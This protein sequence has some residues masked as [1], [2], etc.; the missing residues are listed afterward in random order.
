MK[1]P[2]NGKIIVLDNEPNEAA[3]LLQVLAKN[4][5]PHVYYTG[6]EDLLPRIGDVY[7]DVRVVF[8]DINLADGAVYE[9]T[10]AQLSNT[11]KRIIKPG[12][13]Y[14]AAIWSNNQEM[15]TPLIRDLFENR[16]TQIAPISMVFLTK[17]D[18][19]QYVGGNA[20][21]LDPEHPNVIA[22]LETRID[23]CLNEADAIKLLIEWENSIHQASTDTVFGISNII[24]KDSFWNENLKHLYYKLAH[25]QLGKTIIN[26]D[27][28]GIQ[29]AA[30]NTLTRSFSDQVEMWISKITITPEIDISNEGK[31]F[32]R[33]ING[34]EVKLL[35]KNFTYYMYINGIQKSQNKLVEGLR[36]NNNNNERQIASDLK[37]HYGFISPKL[38]SELLFSKSPK[39]D[40]YPGNVYHKSVTG[41]KKRKLLKTYFPKIM[42][43]NTDGTF[44]KS[45]ISGFRFVEVECTPVC[46]YSQSKSLRFRFLPGVLFKNE[47][48]KHLDSK[49]KSIYQE[50]PPFEFNGAIY[51]L[52]FDYRLFKT[53]NIE[54]DTGFSIDNF[55]FRLKGELLVDIQSRISSH[56]SRP[57]IITIS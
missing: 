8:L 6:D 40:F 32:F 57:G 50:I 37:S 45:D 10:I 14:I 30:L 17:S 24:D 27:N 44:E 29:H 34:S 4:K 12:S 19:F 3:P 47:D 13:P 33:S 48:Q 28:T 26:H 16:E 56:V 46:D 55:L 53:V 15:H 36:A 18:F 22:D 38:N 31:N 41:R 51:R 52:V 2:Q 1:L 39:L 23:N 20:Y 9:A 42:K 54:D 5:I 11:L 7:E 21:I 49:L 43:K 35:W 25:A